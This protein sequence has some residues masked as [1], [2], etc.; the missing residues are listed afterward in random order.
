M[1]VEVYT[2]LFVGKH[3]PWL[4][5]IVPGSPNLEAVCHFEFQLPL[6]RP[7]FCYLLSEA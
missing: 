6:I 4:F 3:I 5:Q 2:E 1:F 7:L